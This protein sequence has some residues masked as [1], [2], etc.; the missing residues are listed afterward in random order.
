MT[1]KSSRFP[2]SSTSRRRFIGSGAALAASG[3][4]LGSG[5]IQP[6]LAQ[7]E[8]PVTIDVW[9]GGEPGTANSYTEI[10]EQYQELHPNVTIN[11]TFVGSD[12]FNPTLLPALNAGEGPSV[13]MGGTGPGQPAAIIDAGHPLDLT[14]YYCELDWDIPEEVVSV[15]SSDGMLWAVGDSVETTVTFY[16]KRIFE[17]NGLVIPES[18]DDFM[19]ACAQLQEAGYAM[20]VGLGAAD[21][22]PISHW[23]TMFWGR[24]AGPEGLDDVMFGDGRWD[25]EPFVEATRKLAEINE[26]GFFGPEP[27]AVFQDDLIAQFWRGEVP[28]VYTGPWVIG[29][30]VRDLGE[31]IEDFGTFQFPPLTEDQVIYPTEGI[32]QGWYIN[33][34]F[35]HPDAAADLLTFMLFRDESRELMLE[36]GD[37]VPVGPIDLDAVELPAL[38]EEVLQSK[39]QYRENGLIHA[40]L[41]TVTPAEMTDVTYDGLQ[42]LI[43]GQMTPE[44]FNA[45]VQ[46]AW[47]Q[48]KA[49][50]LH[51]KEGGVS[52]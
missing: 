10:F 48:A 5:G 20:P 46:A 43:A 23:Q 26:A 42:A 50:D 16:N 31:G 44:E 33:S 32:G 36:S 2:N 14:S 15:T 30:A 40:F 22:W 37:N 39:E 3:A 38:A 49:Q 17:D 51:L 47:E 13:W 52:C 19:A 18:W 29:Q 7:D 24:Y 34:Q 27:L 6:V 11:N 8:E 21:R 45:A 28:M 35:E 4:L 25:D 41:D 9:L 12:L 1:T